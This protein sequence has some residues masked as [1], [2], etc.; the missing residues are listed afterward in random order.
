MTSDQIK[1]RL[2]A[3]GTAGFWITLRSGE[4]LLCERL[5]S[6]D[7]V[8]SI[9][10]PGG[11]KMLFPPEIKSIAKSLAPPVAAI[12]ENG[13]SRRGIPGVATGRSEE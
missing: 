4:Q 8:L 1:E 13:R 2:S 10:G 5:L 11:P 7:S 9:I 3:I 12:V 6:F